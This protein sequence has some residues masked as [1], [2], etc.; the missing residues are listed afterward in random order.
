MSLYRLLSRLSESY[1]PHVISL[2]TIGEVGKRIQQLGI[3]VESLG[4][5]P[6]RP[7]PFAIY[8]LARKLKGLRPDLVH[9]WMY[10][11]D[12]IGGIS[13]RLAGVPAVTWGIRHSNLSPKQNK[14]TTLAV[15]KVCSWLSHHIPDRILCCSEVASAIHVKVGYP[16]EKLLI[17]PNGIDLA[18]YTPDKSARDSVRIELGLSEQTTLIGLIARFD[19]QKN[20][21]GFI[22]AA[23]LLHAQK[24]GVHFLLAG[25]DIET[26]NTDL[27]RWIK[28][29]GIHEVCHLLGQRDDVPRLMA[30]LDISTSSSWGEAFPNVVAE[31]MACGVPCVVTD[32]GDSAYIVGD[33]GKVIL[34]GDDA[35]LADA[36]NTLIALPHEE[37]IALGMRARVRVAENFEL[38]AV[39]KRY[40]SFYEDLVGL[41]TRK[42][43]A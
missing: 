18:Q 29:A 23:G 4:M 31:A 16:A 19:S 25:R 8:Q 5:K 30:A 1:C 14:R 21:E 24:P 2:S 28:E 39:V 17:I 37:R 35:A 10:H 26:N 42:G 3:P 22:R 33:A 13:A 20:H 34:P 27:V 12:L 15:V 6:G 11:A 43:Q 41:K 36:W 32:V 38:G 40:E 7:N 9:T